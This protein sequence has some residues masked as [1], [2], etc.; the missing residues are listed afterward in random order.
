MIQAKELR[1]GNWFQYF[2]KEYSSGAIYGT[3]ESI[4]E[5][6][7]NVYASSSYD[8]AYLECERKF[9]DMHPIPLTP[10]ILE[11]AG[12]ELFPWGWV[13]KSSKDFG[14]RLTVKSFM[15]EVSGNNPVCLDY[16]HQLQNLYFSLT[17]EELN[18]QL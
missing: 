13:K 16:L 6:G 3:I 8:T 18:V 15:Y 4:Y 2:S 10:E 12:F 1:I 17:G 7:V 5:E 11:K 14:V 9:I